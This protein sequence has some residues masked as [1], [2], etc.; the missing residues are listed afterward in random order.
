MPFP[1]LVSG[2]AAVLVLVLGHE[3]AIECRFELNSSHD[4]ILVII[5]NLEHFS[6]MRLS[7][8][9]HPSHSRFGNA[10]REGRPHVNR[11]VF[12]ACEPPIIVAV[13]G[14]KNLCAP[15]TM[16]TKADEAVVVGILHF[17]HSGMVRPRAVRR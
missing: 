7:V 9:S 16:F 10:G 11:H 3:A 17:D 13:H 1:E 5:H 8:L 2:N 6:F 14:L 4:T 15:C 12:L